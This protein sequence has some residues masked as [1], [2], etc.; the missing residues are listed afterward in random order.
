VETGSASEDASTL[1]RW[2]GGAGVSW[3]LFTS[4]LAPRMGW[5]PWLGL[6]AG[7]AMAPWNRHGA[8]R[9]VCISALTMVAFWLGIGFIAQHEP[10]HNLYWKWLHAV[11]PFVF[12][13]GV[14]PLWQGLDRLRELVGRQGTWILIL[15]MILLVGSAFGRETAR[16]LEVSARLY[17]PQLE[18]AQ[19][20]EE[21]L[22]EDA[23]LLVDNIPGCW[24]DRRPHERVLWTWMN[25]LACEDCEI[26]AAEFGDWL[27]AEHIEHVLWFREEWTEA[28]RV[29]PWLGGTDTV[30]AG[31]VS[32]RPLR[33]E[34]DYGWV[35]YR[36]EGES[37]D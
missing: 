6:M 4:V 37:S 36:V 8:R 29:A 24:L 34:D 14:S 1:G 17:G 26:S 5:I 22:P 31:A 15:G 33:R 28:P 21:E 19:W 13:V 10:G 30:E 18:L 7:L 32:L 12:L 16:Q 9:T 23:V 27:L 3:S 20:I 2:L 11:M 25:V 35:F